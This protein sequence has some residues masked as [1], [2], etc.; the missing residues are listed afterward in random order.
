MTI[1]SRGV[2]E[3][4]LVG[5]MTD[6]SVDHQSLEVNVLELSLFSIVSLRVF[7]V[8]E[9]YYQFIDDCSKFSPLRWNVCAF[10]FL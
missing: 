9:S 6:L 2:I 10:C 5:D 1:V 7:L 3:D 4:E 8:L